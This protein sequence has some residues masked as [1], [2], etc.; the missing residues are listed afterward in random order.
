[1][2]TFNPKNEQVKRKYLEW[3]KEA[4]GYSE[5]T[6][7]QIIR[8]IT[9]W[10]EHT[11]R[12]DFLRLDTE[13]IKSFK[14]ILREKI[15]PLT[16]QPLALNTQHHH[17]VYL[18]EFYRWLTMQAGY[19]KIAISDLAYFKLD[20]K[21][22]NIALHRPSKRTPTLEIIQRVIA[23]IEPRNEIDVRDRALIAFALLSGM[24]IDAILSLPI[25][26]FNVESMLITQDP[27]RGVRTKFSKWIPTVI[28]PFDDAAV[29]IVKEWVLFLREDKL[30]VD[31]DPLFPA[32]KIEQ[33]SADN[34][35]FTANSLDRRF[36]KSTSA[37]RSILKK[38]FGNAG[39]EYFNPHSF[40]HAA[41]NIAL[42]RCKT[43]ADFKAVSQ[44]IGHENLATTMFD[45]AE[46]PPEEVARR[47]KRLMKKPTQK[48]SDIPK[49]P[50]KGFNT[51]DHLSG[52]FDQ[53]NQSP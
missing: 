46:L 25:G 50:I 12:Q 28:F 23:S 38:R 14:K 18:G 10:E 9:L 7:D 16:K 39:I 21:Q 26:C 30:F 13:I 37:A 4:K 53:A 41:I 20:R 43:P 8:S 49:R 1:M 52:P 51:T 11:H 33:A 27:N 45:Y 24:R 6:I 2:T 15:N 29:E 32:T 40:R 19:K 3:L 17:L 5:S 31:V 42:A 47:I 48:D 22:T 36:W 35:A 44:N 34:F